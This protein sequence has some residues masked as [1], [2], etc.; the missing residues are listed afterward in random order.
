MGKK[1]IYK[2]TGMTCTSCAM[3]TEQILRKIDG[4]LDVSVTY[5]D[6]SARIETDGSVKFNQMQD[7]LRDFGFAL[8]EKS[9]AESAR[10]RQ[11]TTE[12]N[13]MIAAWAITIPLTLKMLG[14][15]LFGLFIVSRQVAFYIDLALAF[16]VIFI[17]GFPILRSTFNAIRRLSFTMDSLIG[18]GTVASYSTAVMKA[19][20]VEI[21]SFAVVGAMIMSINFI[22]NYLK[23]MA[24]GRAG[25]A[26]RQL[27]QLGAKNALLIDTEGNEQEVPIESLKAGDIV[28]IKPGVK[29][30]VD[31]VIL[32]GNTSIDE[33]IISGEAIP[34]DKQPGDRVT[35]ATVNQQGSLTVRIDKTGEETFLAQVI[36]MVE[37][38]QNSKVPIQ[39][40]ADRVT[41]IFVP[42]ILVLSVA[43]LL[44]WLIFPQ[45]GRAVLSFFDGIIPWVNMDRG[46]VSMALFSAIATLVIACP[47]ALGLATPTA[48]MAGMGKGAANGI[49]IRNGE[50]IQTSRKLDTVV[51][52]KTGTVTEGKPVVSSSLVLDDE[53]LFW[54]VTAAVERMSEHPLSRAIVEHADNKGVE[55]TG[56]TGFTA[57]TGKGVKA[58]WNGKNV[59]IGSINFLRQEDVDTSRYDETIDKYHSNGQTVIG[60]SI[61]KKIIGI[62]GISD[63]IKED[64][65]LAIQR[66]H[67]LGIKT[68]MLT[69]D[70]AQAANAVARSV[71]IDEVRAQLL[72]EDKIDAIRQLQSSGA[73]VAM[74][75]DGIND[76][77][78][79]K[80]ADVGIAIGTGTDIAIEAS[81]ITLVSGRVTGV[82]S[83]IVLSRATFNRIRQNLFWAFFYNIVAVPLAILGVLH[84]V[85]AETA[86]AFSSINVTLNSLR[87]KNTRL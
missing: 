28:R 86:M 61:D 49:L 3:N 15:M 78:A 46:L 7:A 85:I 58:L 23:A 14:E 17:I 26:I 59:I 21:E 25:N 1:E 16:P 20:G 5:A 22:G 73:T 6:Q 47:C 11:L 9:A 42:V 62:T 2:V 44:F 35:G 39:E 19:G 13:R 55:A 37:E 38:A 56:V 33:S 68:V 72:P 80:Q 34:V 24:T 66:L 53:S 81:D 70:N 4:I 12:R 10:H 77:P 76:A 52:D 40:F 75:G 84:P 74:V 27:L 63:S 30:P 36:K 60:T 18:I 8:V 31:G 41:S 64:S 79:L 45:A 69:G 51:F 54:N 87:L 65:A 67:H 83:A 48:L 50:A 43:T 82:Y 71:G 29:V 32:T 57:I